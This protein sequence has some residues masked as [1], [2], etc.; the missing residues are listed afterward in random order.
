MKEKIQALAQTFLFKDVP[1]D[2]LALVADI[3]EEKLVIPG[4]TV[5]RE[6]DFGDSIYIIV[7]GSVK[8]EKRIEGELKEIANLGPGEVFGEVSMVDEEPRLA[9]VQPAEPTNLLKIGVDDLEV[10]FVDHPELT[11][12]VF[13]ALA[14]LLAA[15]LR[16][17]TND[18]TFLRTKTE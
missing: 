5:I 15:R 14:R 12:P 8:V 3:A 13:R 7:S 4:D 10:L 11:A 6:G 1:E 9:T 16:Q 18:M 2:K 17:T